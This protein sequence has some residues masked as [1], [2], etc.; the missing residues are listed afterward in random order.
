MDFN[1][2]NFRYLTEP[3][4]TVV[5]R[6]RRGGRLYLRSLSTTGK[7]SEAAARLEHDFPA[8]GGNFVLPDELGY[9][10]EQLFSSVLRVSGAVNM[11]LH[12]DVSGAPLPL[13]LPHSP[14]N[15]VRRLF[16]SYYKY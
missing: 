2:K 16:A 15:E 5:D 7:P 9:V 8:L 1:A 11:W 6:M 10:R 3:F 12:Y 14:W 13:C 4:G